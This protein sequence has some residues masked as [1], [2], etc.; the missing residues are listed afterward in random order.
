M[1]AAIMLRKG[2]GVHISTT[3][4]PADKKKKPKVSGNKSSISSS[5]LEDTSNWY[6]LIIIENLF[7]REYL[8]N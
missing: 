6:N 8:K 3:L 7:E 1:I 2:K 4:V 5:Y